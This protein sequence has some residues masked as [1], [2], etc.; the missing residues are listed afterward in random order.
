MD[1]APPLKIGLLLDGP[2]VPAWV[3]AAL[4][5]LA[6]A[7]H[8]RLA[9]AVLGGPYGHRMPKGSLLYRLFLGLDR[10]LF[11]PRPDALAPTDL[12]PL[13]ASV[14]C[15]EGSHAD[16]AAL[17]AALADHSLDLLILLEER[18][19]EGPLL[20]AARHGV[21]SCGGDT[22]HTEVWQ[23][24][25][26]TR[27]AWRRLGKKGDAAESLIESWGRTHRL[28]AAVNCNAQHWKHAALLSRAVRDLHQKNEQAQPPTSPARTDD[29]APAGMAAMLAGHTGRA[30]S[31]GLENLRYRGQWGLLLA[32]T[33]AAAGPATPPAGFLPLVPPPDR[34]WAD[35]FVVVDNGR[36]YLFVEEL[37]FKNKNA[38]L[39]VIALD[40]DGQAQEPVTILQR[41]YHLSYPFVFKW[42]DTYYMIPET[43]SNNAVE[44]YVCTR[45]PHTWAFSHN[46]M[47]GTKAADA[48]LYEHGGRW[49]L[50][51]NIAAG[52]GLSTRDELFLFH[53]D[54]PLSSEW[55]PHP[56]NPI[57]SDVRRARPAGRVFARDGRLYRPSQDGSVR[58]GWALNLNRIDTL[59]PTAYSEATVERV[60]PWNKD[61]LGVHTWNHAAGLTAI[62]AKFR[63]ARL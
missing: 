29:S 42:E 8:A 7:A 21:W 3:H 60:E 27:A 52:E 5:P 9:L 30:L 56:L 58:Y 39:A 32:R 35:P 45:F 28:S 46:L 33:P 13:L 57:V 53:A 54:S 38:H 25:P 26:A 15:L 31:L 62:D 40:D 61:I 6:S 18:Q 47:H 12:G 50:W 59:T 14:P 24:R 41:P 22:G 16:E 10:R 43:A 63:R 4:R 34:A 48:T 19:P 51:A 36:E 44:L 55:T 37:L 49:W 1:H 11:K 23:R 17:A 2:I 20:E